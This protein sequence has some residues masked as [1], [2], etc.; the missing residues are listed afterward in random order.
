MANE[1]ETQ[2]PESGPGFVTFYWG[3]SGEKHYG[4]QSTIDATLAVCAAWHELHPDGPAAIGQ[5][6]KRGGGQLGTHTSH[7]TGLDVDVRPERKDGENTEVTI[8]QD[9]YDRGLT[10]ELINLWW[11]KAPV[12]LILF[13]DPT[14]I[15]AKLSQYWDDHHDHFHVR[16]RQK[17]DVIRQ[18]DRGSDVAEVQ[19][20]LQITADGRFWTR[21]QTSS[22]SISGRSQPHV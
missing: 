3:E 20:K 18:G 1:I 15:A 4:Q 19:T 16:L 2:L 21:N 17:G 8:S 10:T 14:V 7:K 13:N 12:R 6:S 22:E 11:E 5:I 9:Q